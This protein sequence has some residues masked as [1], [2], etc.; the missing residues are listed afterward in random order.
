[1]NY[2]EEI[3][4]LLLE[5][6]INRKVKNYSINRSDL[7]TYYNIGKILSDAGKHYGEGI[8]KEYSKKLTNEL[9]KGFTET[10]L[11]YYRQFYY[12]SKSHTLCDD[13]SWSHY[14]LLLSISDYDEIEYYIKVVKIN[15]LS[16]RK[17]QDIIKN[18]EYE[19]LPIDAKNKLMNQEESNIVDFVKNPIIIH[20]NNNENISEKLLQ[21]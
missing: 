12:F 21:R 14:R 3:K 19:R 6:E 15:H 2:Y 1:M 7:N 5:S 17:L 4:K 18:K 13:L 16:V 8:I 11:K 9:G 10:N 20:S